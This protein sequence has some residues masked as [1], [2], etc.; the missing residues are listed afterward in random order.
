M[1]AQIQSSAPVPSRQLTPGPARVRVLVD[2]LEDIVRMVSPEVQIR[3]L[4]SVAL[5]LYVRAVLMIA[6]C[7][8]PEALVTARRAAT[9][10]AAALQALAAA[11]SV[12]AMVTV[13]QTRSQV[14]A[15]THQAPVGGVH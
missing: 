9:D 10:A 8:R 15:C 4:L 1:A 3:E 5:S 7:G 12:E 6:Q 14:D 2:T 13:A 11:P